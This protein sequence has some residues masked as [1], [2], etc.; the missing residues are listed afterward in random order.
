MYDKLGLQE[1]DERETSAREDAFGVRRSDE[2]DDETYVL[3]CTDC[4]PLER[5]L[6]YDRCNSIMKFGSLCKDMKE[7]R[8]AM[9]QYASNNEF[10]L[11]TEASSPF[12]YRGYC[13][14]G[15]RRFDPGGSL[16]R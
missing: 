10:E 4:L 6:A 14:G 1:E 15:C 13:K 12:R 16:D 2:F 5:V 8:L 7:S 3:P 11:G 9:R